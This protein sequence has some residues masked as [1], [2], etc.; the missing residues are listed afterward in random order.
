M[1]LSVALA[2]RRRGSCTPQLAPPLSDSDCPPAAGHHGASGLEGD[3]R[4]LKED[5][6]TRPTQAIVSPFPIVQQ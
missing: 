6:V 4:R 1:V 3:Y 5:V 2:P